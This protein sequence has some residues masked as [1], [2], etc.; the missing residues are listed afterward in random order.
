MAKRWGRGELAIPG[1]RRPRPTTSAVRGRADLKAKEAGIAVRKSGLGGSPDIE[2]R[3]E[4]GRPI[5]M[6]KWTLGS[7]V[8]H[9]DLSVQMET[10][11][12]HKT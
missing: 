12:Y 3:Q 10:A 8:C 5:A 6:K 2:C 7:S 9:L 1:L 11:T 4:S